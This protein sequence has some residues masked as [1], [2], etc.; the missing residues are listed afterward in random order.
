LTHQ[1][2]LPPWQTTGIGSDPHSDP[3]EAVRLILARATVP[4][5]PQ[6]VN[7]GPE[8]DMV[9]QC[10]HGLPCLEVDLTARRV[11]AH[12]ERREDELLRFYERALAGDLD[13]F[14]LPSARGLDALLAA[15]AK[16]PP[17]QAPRFLKGQVVGPVTFGTTAK[18]EAGR[19]IIH[20][21]ELMEAC[22][23][24][25]GLK[26][27]WQARRLRQAGASPIIFFDEPS[28]SG[29]G[30]A[31]MAVEQ[32]TV[33]RLLGLAFA[34]VRELEPGALLGVHCCGNSDW[35]MLLESGA[36]I[37]S[38]DSWSY[39]DAF[40]LYPKQIAAHLERGGYLA[41]GAVPTTEPVPD[42]FGLLLA[43]LT[44][45]LRALEAAGVDAELL[46]R[47][48]LLTPSCGMGLLDLAGAARVLEA[49]AWLREAL[50]AAGR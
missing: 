38:F 21:R 8:E 7:L 23:Q 30:S 37:I 31:F 33:L 1:P 40:C 6:L 36:D 41:W 45:G 27:A 39:L 20:D 5:W 25:L 13:Y 3:G 32:G 9:L 49:L 17:G 12:G 16:L 47:H 19:D 28:L 34:A 44:G 4:F 42:D 18:D 11:A 10:A 26:A 2:G 43:R 46:R 15:V 48:S 29:F 22:S 24:G 35:A 50:L 14:A